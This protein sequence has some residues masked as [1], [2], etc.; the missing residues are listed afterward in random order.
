[1]DPRRDLNISGNRVINVADPT[2][3]NHVATKGY[4]DYLH[5]LTPD[6]DEYE[7]VRYI[8]QR[9][10]TQYS[11]T[12]LCAIEW[13]F[14]YTAQKDE[15]PGLEG[16]SGP[17]HLLESAICP[18]ILR[19]SP[20]QVPNKYIMIKYKFDVRVIN[21]KISLTYQNPKDQPAIN[22]RFIWQVS[23][24]YKRWR[25]I[26]QPENVATMSFRQRRSGNDG[27][28]IFRMNNPAN[29]RAKYWRINCTAG[30]LEEHFY[31]NQLYMEV[32]TGE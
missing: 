18:G 3:P 32:S 15:R 29:V 17:Y 28:L 6:S 19:I 13:N 23:R 9:R 26:T 30:Q 16:T 12:R 4:T 1:M 22:F 25:N 10:D 14:D 5:L 8:N 27:E 24:D 31:V 20:Q 7:Y 2:E 11:L 21:W